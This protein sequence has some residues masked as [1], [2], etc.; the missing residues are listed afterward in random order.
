MCKFINFSVLQDKPVSQ[1]KPVPQESGQTVPQVF[2][3][4]AKITLMFV[5]KAV[6]R[7]G[8]WWVCR[9]VNGGNEGKFGLCTVAA[10]FYLLNRYIC[11]HKYFCI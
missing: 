4:M 6:N 11:Y 7:E 1:D 2:G 10:Q 9:A 3:A 8:D 5:C